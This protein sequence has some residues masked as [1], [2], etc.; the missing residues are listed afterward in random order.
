VPRNTSNLS[1]KHQFFHQSNRLL[2]AKTCC[3]DWWKN[4]AQL[5]CDLAIVKPICFTIS[6]YKS[7]CFQHNSLLMFEESVLTCD[8][9]S[10]CWASKSTHLNC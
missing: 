10:C 8:E 7:G 2:A 6:R 3:L 9:M 4:V 5:V 1:S